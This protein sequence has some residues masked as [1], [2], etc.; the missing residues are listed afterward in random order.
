M[1][2]VA[3]GCAG[4]VLLDN[5]LFEAGRTGEHIRERL[6]E[7]ASPHTPTSDLPHAR[8]ATTVAGLEAFFPARQPPKGGG[9]NQRG[10]GFLFTMILLIKFSKISRGSN[11]YNV[12]N[13]K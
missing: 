3:N 8:R 5:V 13:L 1:A 4:T 11:F 6:L 10:W 7:G 9:E 2:L 12:E